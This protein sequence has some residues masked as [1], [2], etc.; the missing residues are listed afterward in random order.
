MCNNCRHE[1]RYMI[2]NKRNDMKA[3]KA[4]KVM[5]ALCCG[6]IIAACGGGGGSSTTTPANFSGNWSTNLAGTAFVFSIAQT[7]SNFNMTRITPPL[8]G[9]TYTGAVTGNSALVT[10]YIN[11][12]ALGTNTLTLTSTN[13]A[14][15]TVD[16]CSPPP[17]YSCAAPGTT[18]ILTR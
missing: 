10:A 4:M 17:G 9:L 11:N 16:S 15:M 2:F 6:L 14:S 18:L 3:M 12:V 5:F 13:T 8:A 1:I 7:G